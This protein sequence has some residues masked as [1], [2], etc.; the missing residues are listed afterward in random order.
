MTKEEVNNMTV[1]EACDYAVN[2]I[3]E[4]GRRCMEGITC[5]YSDGGN[6]RCFIG[7]LL[8]GDLTDLTQ[9]KG[10]VSCLAVDPL[11]KDMV[12]ELIS[13]NRNLFMTAQRFHDSPERAHRESSLRSLG[14]YGL[15]VKTN[16]N[17]QQWVEMGST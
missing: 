1:Q 13:R 11:T 5:I 6:G 16:P 2:K 17:Y 12:P 15:D 9:V 10:T 4:Q 7:W 8:D 14:V 3:V